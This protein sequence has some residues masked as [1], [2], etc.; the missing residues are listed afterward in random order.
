MILSPSAGAGKGESGAEPEWKEVEVCESEWE[1][2][3]SRPGPAVAVE[4]K[5]QVGKQKSKSSIC[6]CR[7]VCPWASYRTSLSLCKMGYKDCYDQ[8]GGIGW[9]WVEEP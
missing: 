7:A 2:R 9:S 1:R 3:E 4:W 5:Q 6:E 8:T